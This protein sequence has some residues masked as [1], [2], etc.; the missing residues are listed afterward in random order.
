MRRVEDTYRGLS[1]DLTLEEWRE[2]SAGAKYVDNAMRLT[3]SLQ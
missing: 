2:R 1:R 3:S